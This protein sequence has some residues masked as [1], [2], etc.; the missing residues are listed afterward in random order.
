[1]VGTKTNPE[2]AV[3]GNGI[4][5]RRIFLEGALVAGATGAGL[6]SASAEPLAVQPWMKVPGAGFAGYGQPSRFE[7]KVVRFIPPP[8]NPATQGVGAGAHAAAP[9]RRHHHAVRAA[10]RAQPLRHSG[11]RSRSAPAASSTGW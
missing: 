7:D 2:P 11:H 3:A 10:L 1:M 4:L 9:A 5:S 8:P 6:S